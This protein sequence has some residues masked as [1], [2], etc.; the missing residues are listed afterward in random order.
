MLQTPF[1]RPKVTIGFFNAL[2]IRGK[3]GGRDRD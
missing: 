2:N 1:L 3:N